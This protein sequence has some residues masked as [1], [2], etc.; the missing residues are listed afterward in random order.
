MLC[1]CGFSTRYPECVGTHK[2]VQSVKDKITEAIE[3][4][5]ISDGKLNGLG[6]KIIVLEI[7]KNVKGV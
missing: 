7:I 2:V 3:N 6:M 4:V 5:D 1:T